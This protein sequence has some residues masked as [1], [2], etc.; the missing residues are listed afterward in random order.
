LLLGKWLIRKAIAAIRHLKL[1]PIPTATLTAT[2][3]IVT[4]DITE[5]TMIPTTTMT[6]GPTETRTLTVWQVGAEL[7]TL[8]IIRS[9]MTSACPKILSAL[10]IAPLMTGSQVLVLSFFS[11][12]VS[13]D[14]P[15]AQKQRPKRLSNQDRLKLL[16]NM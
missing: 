6:M 15:V 2:T 10:R 9:S 16:L 12:A 7:M 5:V 3:A 1:R 8:L 4:E 13:V 14:V 11:V